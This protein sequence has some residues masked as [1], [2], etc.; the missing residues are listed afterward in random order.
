[1]QSPSTHRCGGTCRGGRSGRRRPAAT[2]L[3]AVDGQVLAE[4]AH[5]LRLAGREVARER[6]RLPVLPEQGAG[7]RTGPDRFDGDIE[8]HRGAAVLAV[9]AGDAMRSPAPLGTNPSVRAWGTAR[10]ARDELVEIVGR[11]HEAAVQLGVAT[12]HEGDDCVRHDRRRHERV[13]GDLGAIGSC[14]RH[15]GAHQ[16]RPEVED[17]HAGAGHLRG[18][19]AGE[20]REGGLGRGVRHARLPGIV[21]E[22]RAAAHVDDVTAAALEHRRQDGAREERGAAHVGLDDLPPLVRIGIDERD[23]WSV[24]AGRADQDFDRTQ[25]R[26]RL[27]RTRPPP[28]P[29]N[30][31][32]ACTP[33]TGTPARG[34]DVL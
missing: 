23:A 30:L 13:V 29:A 17:E 6:D 27:G 26:R 21:P 22:G 12:R 31:T 19:R 1:M 10:D 15:V 5:R 32:S 4:H 28:P 2:R 3:V 9:K 7:R 8:G 20:A 33:T 14:R 16:A 11:V 24:H 34:L 25:R 18:E